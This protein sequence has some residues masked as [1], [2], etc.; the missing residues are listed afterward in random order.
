M[1]VEGKSERGKTEGGGGGGGGEGASGEKAAIINTQAG[2]P[3]PI[4]KQGL[5]DEISNKE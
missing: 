5:S 1:P 3:F 2:Q 4:Q